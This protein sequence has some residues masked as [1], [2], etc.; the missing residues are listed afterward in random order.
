MVGRLASAG[1]GLPW[2]CVRFDSIAQS[3]V[4]KLS[5]RYL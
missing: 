2:A 1:A 4:I 3:N 5:M